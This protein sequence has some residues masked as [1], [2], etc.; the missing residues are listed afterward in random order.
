MCM[1]RQQ[2][3]TQVREWAASYLFYPPGPDK[4]ECDR[5]YSKHTSQ[6]ETHRALCAKC[7]DERNEGEA[8]R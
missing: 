4:D 2:I 1:I 7:R 8:S 5:L 6:L 3:E